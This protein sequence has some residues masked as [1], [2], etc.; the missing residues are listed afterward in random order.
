MS[1][2]YIKLKDN[3]W[4]I[5]VDGTATVG[6]SVTVSKKNGDTK[7]ET[8]TRVLFTGPDKFKAGKTVSLCAIKQ[9]QA[10]YSGGRVYDNATERNS[11]GAYCGYPCPVT[12]RK[13][14]PANGPCHD[15]Q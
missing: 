1:A 9:R 14:C 13:C 3:S 2:S 12:G 8:I 4:G 11:G 6:Q 5:R 7:N 10:A 15:C